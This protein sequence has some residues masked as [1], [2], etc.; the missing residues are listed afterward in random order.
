MLTLMDYESV[1]A[2]LEDRHFSRAARRLN[3]TQPALTARLHRIEGI[4]GSRLF[5]RGRT[6]V[7]PT[8]TGIAFAEGARRVL[9]AANQTLT[10]VKNA[11]LGLGEMLTIGMTQT[12]A[13]TVVVPVLEAFCQLRPQAR[14]RLTQGTTASLEARLESRELDLAFLHPPLHAPSLAEHLLHR[15]KLVRVNPAGDGEASPL[16]RYPRADAPVLMGKLGREGDA[17]GEPMRGEAD[18]MLGAFILSRAGFGTCV[19]DEVYLTSVF[20]RGGETM[21]GTDYGTLETS[22]AWRVDEKRSIVELFREC[23]AQSVVAA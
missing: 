22:L 15:G 5:D 12:A 11:A 13:Y 2:L 23:A 3:I 16:I 17:A 9:E 21:R 1:L 10:E 20:P 19:I 4:V 8:P 18:T 14:I 7:T 6:G